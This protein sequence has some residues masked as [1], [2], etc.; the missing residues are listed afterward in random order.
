MRGVRRRWE[1]GEAQLNI[2]LVSSATAR[3]RTLTL[4]WRHG[5]AGGFV[6]LVLFVGFTL[7]FNSSRCATQPPPSIR[8][9]RRS[10][11]PTSEEALKSQEIV[12][13]HL[14]AMAL[15]WAISRRR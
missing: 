1:R 6:L 9:C 10:C 2:I 15:G 11:S 4:D 13:G 14:N 5:L 8:G 12:Q 7:I 3:A